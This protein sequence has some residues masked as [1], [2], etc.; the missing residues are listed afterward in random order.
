MVFVLIFRAAEGH[1][2]WRSRSEIYPLKKFHE[3][4]SIRAVHPILHET[5]MFT[6]NIFLWKFHCRVWWNSSR[7]S[8]FF[9]FRKVID[10][11]IEVRMCI[12]CKKNNKKEFYKKSPTLFILSRLFIKYCRWLRHSTLVPTKVL[13]WWSSYCWRCNQKLRCLDFSAPFNTSTPIIPTTFNNNQLI[14]P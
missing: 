1:F 8:E 12:Y 10:V 9:L 7:C 2:I 6:S 14:T 13:R 4:A 5:S 3:G 11:I